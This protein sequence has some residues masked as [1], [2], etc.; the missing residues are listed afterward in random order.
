MHAARERPSGFCQRFGAQLMLHWSS[1]SGGGSSER[2][3]MS[4]AIKA[5]LTPRRK[6]EMV[7]DAQRLAVLYCRSGTAVAPVFS[8]NSYPTN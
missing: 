6:K 2:K 5:Q 1:T 7:V 3:Q 8:L 4:G